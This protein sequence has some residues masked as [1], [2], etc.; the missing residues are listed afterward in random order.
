[1]LHK[2]LNKD[3][4]NAYE[5]KSNEL[6]VPEYIRHDNDYCKTYS[7]GEMNIGLCQIQGDRRSQEDYLTVEVEGVKA[8]HQLPDE[9]KKIALELTFKQ[10]QEK[11]GNQKEQGSTA[12]VSTGWIDEQQV[13]HIVTGNLGDSS[14]YV[15]ILDEKNQIHVETRLNTLHKPTNEDEQARILSE[16]GYIFRG[17]MNSKLALSRAFGDTAQDGKGISHTPD[18]HFFEHPLS[19]NDKAFLIVT[20]DGLDPIA[21]KIGKLISNNKKENAAEIAN[22]LVAFALKEESD[23]NISAAVMPVSHTPASIAIFDGHGGEIV[24]KN[25]SAYFYPALNEEINSML[26]PAVF[27]EKQQKAASDKAAEE[28]A[29]A[30][31]LA[32]KE[33]N[34]SLVKKK[35]DLYA[36]SL[37]S[38]ES[39]HIFAQTRDT[40]YCELVF[41]GNGHYNILEKIVSIGKSH[42]L[43]L[44]IYGFSGDDGHPTKARCTIR[45]NF[46]DKEI[47][48]IDSFIEEIRTLLRAELLS[49]KD[50]KQSDNALPS[51]KLS[52]AKQGLFATKPITPD[53]P[54]TLPLIRPL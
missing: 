21:D 52:Q 33:K 48:Q 9:A 13:L 26:T 46:K 45:Y 24:S 53:E 29:K 25:I 40:K 5:M 8:F 18:I 2:N 43:N 10:M 54:V 34:Y 36:A 11:Y 41:A 4:S 12:C 39:F 23:D 19:K 28:K 44:Y 49:Q 42:G 3:P 30:E 7:T 47:P 22:L 50:Q 16:D 38:T 35:F 6:I 32:L 27:L 20:S 37:P 31:L 14:A 51:Q 15:V 1:M 17:Y